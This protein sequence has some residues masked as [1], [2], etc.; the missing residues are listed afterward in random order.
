MILQPLFL[1]KLKKVTSRLRKA[2]SRLRL[3]TKRRREVTLR[4]R[5][6]FV[7]FSLTKRE[8][9]VLRYFNKL[10]KSFPNNRRRSSDRA[11]SRLL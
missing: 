1:L 9:F 7:D 8:S 6:L 3:L 11:C 10:S 2:T 5:K 4:K